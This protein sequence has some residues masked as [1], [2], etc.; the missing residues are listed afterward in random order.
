M[1]RRGAA[2][3]EPAGAA[4]GFSPVTSQL[5]VCSVQGLSKPPWPHRFT[6][7]AAAGS[8][9]SALTATS[10]PDL[11]Q[12]TRASAIPRSVTGRLGY[13]E[14]I[15]PLVTLSFQPTQ[16][17]KIAGT[18]ARDKAQPSA[19]VL[20]LI[21]TP[22]WSAVG[23]CGRWGR[24]CCLPSW[25]RAAQQGSALSAR[26]SALSSHFQLCTPFTRPQRATDPP[27]GP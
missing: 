27:L 15:V 16:T 1:K 12:A 6:S 5:T 11:A 26:R 4:G 2:G 19:V 24:V 14:A 18:V 9:R 20:C 10:L 23:R 13:R 21:V 7:S 22:L 8:A 17:L 25:Q 3:A